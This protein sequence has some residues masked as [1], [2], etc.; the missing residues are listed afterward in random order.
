MQEFNISTHSLTKRLTHATDIF[1][2]W[3][4]YFNS[5]PHEEA[6]ARMYSQLL[7]GWYFNSQ[8]HEEADG[9]YQAEISVYGYF[10]SQPHEEADRAR[11]QERRNQW[12]FNSQ[13]HEEADRQP[14][15]TSLKLSTFQLTASRRGWPAIFAAVAVAIL[16]QLTASRRGWPHLFMSCRVWT[17]FNSQPHEE[18]DEPHSL[19]VE[20]HCKFQLTASR[21]GWQKRA[22]IAWE[23]ADISTHSLTKRLT[24]TSGTPL[25]VYDISTHSLTKRLTIFL[26]KKITTTIFQLTASRR[27]WLQSF[28]ISGKIVYFNSQ[29]HEE[30]D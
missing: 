11:T 25:C 22:E 17:Y 21:R 14:Q 23:R 27:G 20:Q 30:A 18:A 7:F 29:P 1:F 12:N 9:L 19:F 13:P 15:K 26:R 28:T 4:D 16:F 3:I 10:S 8:P 24:C 2:F 6:D 5:Q